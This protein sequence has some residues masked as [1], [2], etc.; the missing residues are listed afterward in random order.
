MSNYAAAKVFY[1]VP[2]GRHRS[3]LFKM[4]ADGLLKFTRPIVKSGEQFRLP[5]GFKADFFQFDS[6]AS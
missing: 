2:L 3:H 6:P 1:N 5:S 4:Y